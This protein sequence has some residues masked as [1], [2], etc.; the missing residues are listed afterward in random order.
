VKP[1]G[2]AL[3]QANLARVARNANVVSH[4]VR[5]TPKGREARIIGWT[6]S[7]ND[8]LRLPVDGGEALPLGVQ[9]AVGIR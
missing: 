4:R 8:A 3:C 5:L 7:G 9:L 1:H 2:P 6:N